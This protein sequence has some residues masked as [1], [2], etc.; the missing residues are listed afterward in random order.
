MI[1]LGNHQLE[2]IA[3]NLVTSKNQRAKRRLIK[4]NISAKSLPDCSSTELKILGF[5]DDEINDIKN[6]YIKMAKEATQ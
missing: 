1:E 3:F 4:K 6:N 5:S 2:R